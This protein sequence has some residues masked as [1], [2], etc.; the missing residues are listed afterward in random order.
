MTQGESTTAAA[1]IVAAEW[2]SIL[3]L[4]DGLIDPAVVRAAYAQ[5]RLRELHPGV[6]HGVL[7]LS[8]CTDF[9]RSHVPVVYRLGRGGYQVTAQ[10]VGTL[11]EVDTLEEAFALVVAN[12]P[13]GCGPAVIGTADDVPR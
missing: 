6:S 4:E 7:W 11:G 2:Q 13:E 9:P 10:S 1:E 8:R 3:A 12:L 5:P